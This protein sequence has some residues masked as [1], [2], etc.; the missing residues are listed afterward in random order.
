MSAIQSTVF[1]KLQIW[2]I[3]AH[4]KKKEKLF[5]AQYQFYNEDN[6]KKITQKVLSCVHRQEKIMMNEN[7]SGSLAFEAAFSKYKAQAH[8]L[9]KL[10]C[11]NL[12]CVF[13]REK[14]RKKKNIA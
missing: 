3:R 11:A 12:Q 1:P 6:E 2:L 10:P 8:S 13:A 9:Q 14:V 4:Q 7:L 5:S